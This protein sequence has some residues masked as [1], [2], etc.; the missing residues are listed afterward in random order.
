MCLSDFS[1]AQI[2]QPQCTSDTSWVFK[3]KKDSDS[4]RCRHDSCRFPCEMRQGNFMQ[5]VR[6]FFKRYIYI[7]L[8]CQEWKGRLPSTASTPML[9]SGTMNSCSRRPGH[10][11]ECDVKL[12]LRDLCLIANNRSLVIVSACFCCKRGCTFFSLSWPPDSLISPRCSQFAKVSDILLQS[13]G[14]GWA[15]FHMETS[16]RSRIRCRLVESTLPLAGLG[17]VCVLCPQSV[18]IQ[19]LGHTTRKIVEALRHLTPAHP[20]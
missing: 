9:Q 14:V 17:K 3:W 6:F 11:V 15:C 16:S 2:L 19:R 13:C 10:A 4:G 5:A 8:T 7:Y 1:S 20:N 12:C 18:R